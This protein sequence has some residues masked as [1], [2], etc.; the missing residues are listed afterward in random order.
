MLFPQ[1]NERL[2]QI[3]EAHE[4]TFNWI[5]RS[6]PDVNTSTAMTDPGGSQPEQNTNKFAKWLEV[7]EEPIFWIS[8]KAAS[9]K[10]TLMKNIYKKSALAT[11]LSR[12]YAKWPNNLVLASFFFYDQGK[13]MLQMSREGL[14]RTL[15]HQVLSNGRKL[16][17]YVFDAKCQ[18]IVKSYD[19]DR[20]K[21]VKEILKENFSTSPVDWS[22]T[23][24]NV[25]WRIFASQK[26]QNLKVFLLV[27][28]LD[29]FRLSNKFDDYIEYEDDENSA[30]I[31]RNIAAHKDI[32]KFFLD[33]S[34][35]LGFK[36]CL[37]SRPLQVFEDAFS[38]FPCFKLQ[39]LTLNDIR[40]Y[41]DDR[42]R[43]HPRIALLSG[44]DRESWQ[45][46][47]IANEISSNASGVFLWV[48]LVV[49]I[50]LDSLDAGDS[51]QQLKEKIHKIP[52]SLRGPNGLYARMLASVLPEYQE[53]GF[54]LLR[55]VLAAKSHLTEL[56]ISFSLEPISF[57]VNC[58][59][60]RISEQSAQLKKDEINRRLKSRCGGLLETV[61]NPYVSRLVRL[62]SIREHKEVWSRVSWNLRPHISI[63]PI[64]SFIHRTAA[65][66]FQG[67][68]H[69]DDETHPARTT[70]KDDLQLLI[71]C[72]L[73]IK[74]IGRTAHVWEIS[75]AVKDAH[76]YANRIKKQAGFSPSNLLNEIDRS[77]CTVWSRGMSA[78]RPE[79]FDQDPGFGSN[80]REARRYNDVPEGQLHPI[81]SIWGPQFGYQPSGYRRIVSR[82]RMLA[83][84]LRLGNISSMLSKISG[85]SR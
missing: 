28:G 15:L 85:R 24:L 39:D 30:Q 64:V 53:E 32:A 58:P 38:K 34:T 18:S 3:E 68:W 20:S 46:E 79:D 57:A 54:S 72:L 84:W 52:R 48:K 12:S 56:V 51:I 44:V 21:K 66:Y 83:E 2:D 31:R 40:Q 73:R 8:G 80:V 17:P 33:L 59:I 75:D 25:A 60:G 55:Q 63:D 62:R 22:W 14:L 4:G 47:E 36:L 77:A 41:V 19:G 81:I 10:S 35:C 13:S 70:Y 23:D 9:G 5:L 69:T 27:D 45:V 67:P 7:D 29:E 16:W 43:I 78:G 49:N 1:I 11:I 61:Q 26:P 71:S 76:S 50:A 37:S 74:L 82:I 6:E 65:E 42:L